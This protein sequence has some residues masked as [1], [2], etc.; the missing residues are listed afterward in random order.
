[1]SEAVARVHRHVTT[2]LE[3]VSMF[4]NMVISQTHFHASLKF[5]LGSV[6][7]RDQQRFLKHLSDVLML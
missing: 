6:P 2:Q 5:A 7:Y 3:S 4:L 1:V